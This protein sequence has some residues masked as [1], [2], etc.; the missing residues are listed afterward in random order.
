MSR[1]PFEV[2]DLIV[3]RATH[4]RTKPS[5]DPLEACEVLLAFARVGPPHRVISMNALAADIAPSLTTLPTA[6]P[7]V[8]DGCP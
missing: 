8:S 5:V 6:L 2:A 7:E 4:H 1:P 3:S